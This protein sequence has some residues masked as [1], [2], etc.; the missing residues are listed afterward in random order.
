M[1]AQHDA[2]I[3]SVYRTALAKDPGERSSFL[4]AACADDPT[5]RREVELLLAYA[6]VQRTTPVEYSEALK[7]SQQTAR[8]PASGSLRSDQTS[9]V[10][11]SS[12]GRYRILRF[13]GEGGMGVVYEA[14]QEHPRRTVALKIIKPGFAGH[15]MLRRFEQESLALGRLQH[16]GIAQIYEAGT[17]D[18]GFGLQPYFA[19]ELIRGKSLLQYADTHQ[20]N[21]RQRLELIVKVC[22]AVQHAHQRGIIHRDLKPGN[23]LVDESGQP[24][25]LDFGVARATD[26]DAQVTLQTDVGQLVGTLAYMSPEQVLADPL[27]I[28]TR[29]DVYSLGVILYE[30]LAGRLPYVIST[31]VDEAVRTIREGDP[32]PLRSINRSY[33]GDIETIV[34]K[35]LEKDKARRYASAAGMAADIQRYLN[36]EPIS[37]RRPSASYQLQKFARRYKVPVA[38]AAAFFLLL[39]AALAVTIK[40]YLKAKNAQDSAQAGELLAWA[41]AN[42]SDSPERSLILGLYSWGKQ[43]VLIPGLEQCLHD[44]ILQSQSRLTLRGHNDSVL[45]VAWSPDGGKL[46][47]ASGDR[48]AKVWDASTGRDVLTLRGHEK[49]VLSVAWSPDGGKLATASADHTAKVWEASTGRELLTLR[50]HQQSVSS[51]AWSPD[52]SKL[53]TGSVDHT[54]K[55]WEA[56]TGRELLTLSG[57]QQ[58]V[59]SVAWSPIGN[60]IASASWDHT[61]KVWEVSTGKMLREFSEVEGRFYTVAWSPDGSKLAA[62]SWD[63]T[64]RVWEVST[65]TTLLTLSG[66]RDSVMSVAWSADGKRLATASEDRTAKMWEAST[67]RELVTFH[68]HQQSAVNVA[69]SP[70]GGK[71]ATASWDHTAKVWEASRGREL[72][73]LRGHQNAIR[74]VAWSSDGSK[75]AT[76]SWDSTAKVWEASTGRELLALRSHQKPIRNVAWS[77]DGRKLATASEDRAAKIWDASSGRELLTIRGHQAAVYS[78]AWSP[79]G[80]RL[81]TGSMD[82]TAKV[83]D[84]STGGELMTLQNH[85]DYVWDVAWSPDG[86]RLATASADHT[87]KVWDARTG[88]ELLTLDRHQDA[89]RSVRWSPDGRRLATASADHTAKVWD[90]RTGRE[91]LTLGAHQD[92]VYSLAW[93]PDGRNLA[94]A[95]GDHTAMVWDASTGR[96][97]LT[98]HARDYVLGVAWSPDSKH[99][100]AA[101]ADDYLTGSGGITQVY[102]ID[103]V[104]LLKL[105]RSRI[106]RPLT[107]NECQRYFG[108]EACPGLPAIP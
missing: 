18:S 7:L 13:L 94:T 90:A 16:P 38:A 10:L 65:G 84:A 79:D 33:R 73:A 61:V 52:S 30:L 3:E 5:L 77:P 22:E 60:Q 6:D 17:A 23:I 64:A 39:V 54:V 78:V 25:V 57:H 49:S 62:G 100:A 98:L 59:S 97:L 56:S 19:M 45:G 63:H 31:Q 93:S 40:L 53:A 107:S 108:T 66:H 50:G 21:T 27:E 76:G 46:A 14:E 88:R 95:S 43:R 51:V 105:V 101:G 1:G 26:T 34:G 106:T 91:L 58:S 74:S 69:W 68:G 55:V 48:T 72:L 99:L 20:L 96:E 35:A 87:T 104:E 82:H 71:L 86:R 70:D 32:V 81:A 41:A 102:A 44:A 8:I 67:G 85:Q 92:P 83:W 42:L 75:L 9:D 24:K 103:P 2:A 29:S 36:N 37:A 15:Q 12:I 11:P 28:D 89:V 80:T 47:T 4:D